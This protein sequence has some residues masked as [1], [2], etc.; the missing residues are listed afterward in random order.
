MKVLDQWSS[1]LC[2][3]LEIY[4]NLHDFPYTPGESSEGSVSSLKKSLGLTKDAQEL[5]RTGLHL[6]GVDKNKQTNKK[7][8]NKKPLQSWRG[9]NV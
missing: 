2:T 5:S 7:T 9:E 3:S 1:K 4:V 6:T 8:T